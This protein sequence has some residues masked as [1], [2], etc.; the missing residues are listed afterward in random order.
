MSILQP[1]SPTGRLYVGIYGP[2]KAGKSYTAT[3]IAIAAV[4]ALGL[5]GPIAAFDTEQAYG[6]QA[7][8]VKR[9]TGQ[10]LLKADTRS[11]K[12]LTAGLVEAKKI[13]CSVCIVDSLT[14]FLR[15]ARQ[16]HFDAKGIKTPE[17]S[18]Y[19]A[20]DKGFKTLLDLMLQSSSN[21]ILVGREG[22]KYGRYK[23]SSGRMVS[24]P[25]ATKM[26]AGEAGYECDLLLEVSR[27]EQKGGGI[28]RKC[29]VKG[30]RGDVVGD[31]VWTVPWSVEKELAPYFQLLK[32]G[33]SDQQQSE[34]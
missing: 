32:G 34:G 2:E 16:K 17:P 14:H 19:A 4:L 20:A 28:V 5:K 22:Q 13:G 21:L 8:R 11:I 1:A 9:E 29:T 31:K 23:N 7:S 24:G 27:E 15:E 6:F 25:V 12:E 30:E 18:D 3:S 10:D 26:N 33:A